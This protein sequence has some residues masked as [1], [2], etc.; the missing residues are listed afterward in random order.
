M[1]FSD[2]LAYLATI[3][4]LS[5]KATGDVA[6]EK[7]VELTTIGDGEYSLSRAFMFRDNDEISRRLGRP[8][9][10]QFP[11]F[12]AKPYEIEYRYSDLNKAEDMWLSRSMAGIMEYVAKKERWRYSRTIYSAININPQI[13]LKEQQT[14][15][16]W[17]EDARMKFPHYAVDQ[18]YIEDYP[19]M[20]T[21][22]A[23]VQKCVNKLGDLTGPLGIPPEPSNNKYDSIVSKQ[24]YSIDPENKLGGIDV[25]Y[26]IYGYVKPFKYHTDNWNNISKLYTTLN[27]IIRKNGLD[28][29]DIMKK[30][31]PY[32]ES[33]R[34]KVCNGYE[35][36]SKQ[37]GTIDNIIKMIRDE[38]ET[39]YECCVHIEALK[40]LLRID[41]HDPIDFGL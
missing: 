1:V 27:R 23:E 31:K 22:F 39:N 10:H 20:W 41:G 29:Y 12:L 24:F 34:D 14:Y 6:R 36:V 11:G 15:M 30:E 19:R 32:S 18:V 16:K 40:F 21:Y 17:Y 35:I 25:K 13:V 28:P 26:M 2:I 33:L 4:W 9:R 37:R 7:R 3:S 38:S 8:Y 5:G